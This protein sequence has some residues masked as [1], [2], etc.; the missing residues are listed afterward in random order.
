M[1][2]LALKGLRNAIV[3]K[4]DFPSKADHTPANVYA[5]MIFAPV[6]LTLTQ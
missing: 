5:R 4:I 2:Q 1:E 6:T 3:S